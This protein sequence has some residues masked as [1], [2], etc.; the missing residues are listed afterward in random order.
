MTNR[1]PWSILP[2]V[3]ILT[4]TTRIQFQ[5]KLFDVSIPYFLIKI[6]SSNRTR[7]LH[8]MTY[9]QPK[10][11][12]SKSGFN[13]FGKKPNTVTGNNKTSPQK[14]ERSKF[15]P[16]LFIKKVEEQTVAPVYKAQ[17]TFEDFAIAKQVKLNIATKGYTTP[18]PIQDKAIPHLLECRDIIAS[19]NTGTG[20]TAAFLIP[21]INNVLEKKTERVL[22]I[23][24]TRELADQIQ[25]E[26][27]SFASKTGL[28]ST[29]CIGG[30]RLI[31][32]V[33]EL[34]HDPDFVIGTPGRLRDLANN[35]SIQFGRYDAVVLDEVDRM[36]DMG[37]I[38]D[39]KQI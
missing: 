22:I 13:R 7:K 6:N 16:S 23:A 2:I 34:R 21:L 14:R 36:L 30:S 26:F 29:L 35:N 9:S 12:Q 25:A 39:I 3:L 27:Q 1:I 8:Y 17:H 37:F 4:I 20:K 33:K 31:N 38:Q 10:Q 5:K 24:P 18:T 19:A 28:F 32:Q 11:Q 15:N